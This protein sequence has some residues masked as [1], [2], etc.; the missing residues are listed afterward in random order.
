MNHDYLGEVG[1]K[2]HKLLFLFLTSLWCERENI[3]KN[4]ICDFICGIAEAKGRKKKLGKKLFDANI[5]YL[6]FLFW[7]FP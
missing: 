3:T 5:F 2:R 4:K 1:E 7:T 6:S